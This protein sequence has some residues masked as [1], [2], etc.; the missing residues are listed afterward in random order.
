MMMSPTEVEKPTDLQQL[1]ACIER[2]KTNREALDKQGTPWFYYDILN[3]LYLRMTLDMLNK[4][5]DLI[6][7]E[8]NRL[9][10]E[11]LQ[12]QKGSYERYEKRLRT[13]RTF[14]IARDDNG[15]YYPLILTNSKNKH[16]DKESK[17]ALHNRPLLGERRFLSGATEGSGKKFKSG[18]VYIG[19]LEAPLLIAKIT[20]KPNYTDHKDV[21]REF[22]NPLRFEGSIGRTTAKHFDS[23]CKR[24]FGGFILPD[25]PNATVGT[26]GTTLTQYIKTNPNSAIIHRIAREFIQNLHN[27]HQ[28]TGHAHL[29]L[30][31]DNL[32]I[33][34]DATG[35]ETIK[36]FDFGSA[37]LIGG[38]GRKIT[39]PMYAS[40]NVYAISLKNPRYDNH[41]MYTDN[42]TLGARLYTQ[43][44]S[45]AR[46]EST[47]PA[48]WGT[49]IIAD[50]LWSAGITLIEMYTGL[51][52]M[53]GVELMPKMFNFQQVLLSTE[54]Q[55][56]VERL[57]SRIPLEISEILRNHIF[58]PD[59][60]VREACTTQML[61][62]AFQEKYSPSPITWPQTSSSAPALTFRR[63][64]EGASE[65]RSA[66]PI[67]EGF[68]VKPEFIKISL[69]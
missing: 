10:R 16:D 68:K 53:K 20:L 6:I 63:E 11:N 5:F 33:L 52:P 67:I 22:N 30:K 19:S 24:K 60:L 46:V 61:L 34:K 48:P 51:A 29:D 43:N 62:D 31:G 32:L 39:T 47:T 12:I 14:V 13:S 26:V 27:M 3:P 37:R 25:G 15:D 44:P 54:E 41:D 49:I 66:A 9:K 7:D 35:N 40:P 59:P 58:S 21:L 50:D 69:A 56:E 64:P 57:W 1:E 2:V 55:E 45:S 28:N 42:H 4:E 8:L 18:A 38:I 17:K 23:H 36:I 65:A